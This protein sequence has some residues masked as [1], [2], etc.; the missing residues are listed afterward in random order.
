MVQIRSIPLQTAVA[1]TR[2]AV[3]QLP[4]PSASSESA[5]HHL[6]T[7]TTTTFG[8]CVLGLGERIFF[9]VSLALWV[10]VGT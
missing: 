10:L 6:Q 8:R 2:D 1:A 9:L 7:L 3:Q 5:L 4:T